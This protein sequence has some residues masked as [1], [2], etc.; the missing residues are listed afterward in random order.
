MEKLVSIVVPV[1]NVE[2]YLVECIESIRNQT[3]KDIEIILVNDGSQDK[4]GYI[5]DSY[6]EL[7]ER[8]VVIHQENAGLTVTRRNGV[9]ASC[10][11]FIGFVDGDDWIEPEFYEKLYKYALKENVDIV[12]SRG[13]RDYGE[14]VQRSETLGDSI[15]IGKYIVD[16]EEHYLLKHVFSG[17]FTGGKYLN[18]AVW[19]KLFRRE[20]IGKVLDQMNDNIHGFMDDNVCVVGAVIG[21]ESV[22]VS[23]ACYYHHRERKDAFTYSKNDRGLLQ[24]NYAYLEF[25]KMIN[26]SKYTELL[27]KPLEEHVSNRIISAYNLLFDNPNYEL[28]QYLFR[29]SQMPVGS[30]ILLYGFGKVGKSY[31]KQIKAEGKYQL[32]AVV[33]KNVSRINIEGVCS[34]DKINDFDFDFILIANVSKEIAAAIGEDLKQRN[35]DPNKIM[36]KRP[37]TIFQ[38]YQ[39]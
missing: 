16:D 32:V 10:G 37:V 18:G 7:D 2:K 12:T 8:I 21:A 22:Y 23:D 25:K 30:K 19:N 36:W 33:D 38:Y 1:Y 31:I 17:A 39:N 20:I 6:K 15:S 34:I 4:S 5:C 29:T 11:K 24:I 35:I 3:L 13:Y 28:P 27:L 14:G 9:N 26:N